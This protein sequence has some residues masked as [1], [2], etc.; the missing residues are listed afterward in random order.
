MFFCYSEF[1]AYALVRQTIPM[2]LR[3]REEHVCFL[4][5]PF[6]CIYNKNTA[7]NSFLADSIHRESSLIQ[8]VSYKR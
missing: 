2:V 4:M 1:G 8:N 3:V 7:T 5:C 6:Y